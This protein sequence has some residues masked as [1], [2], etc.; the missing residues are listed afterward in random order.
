[1]STETKTFEEMTNK[2]LE[3]LVEDFDLSVEAKNPKK[4]NKA[5][6]LVCLNA[7]KQSQDE[8]NSNEVESTELDAQEEDEVEEP[9]IVVAA[10]LPPRQRKKLQTADLMRKECVVIT[11]T[12]TT[13]TPDKA[14]FVSW[15]NGLLGHHT[16]VIHMTGKPQ[17]VRRGALN[18]LR[19]VII[20]EPTQEDV[21]DDIEWI[22]RPRFMI[23]DAAGLTAAE[24]KKK[25]VEQQIKA[26]NAL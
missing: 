26:A 22:K 9:K 14:M 2:E 11:D 23:L 1:M 25:A 16:D 12:R 19:N 7:F 4:P 10:K 6:L 24:I 5:E 17:Y 15:G 18:N 3:N 20:D 8:V 21:Y 13:Q